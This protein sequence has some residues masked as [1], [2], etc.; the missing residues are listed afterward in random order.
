[1]HVAPAYEHHPPKEKKRIFFFCSLR[2]LRFYFSHQFLMFYYVMLVISVILSIYV[3]NRDS[4]S[5]S[6]LLWVFIIMALPVFGSLLYLLFGGRKIPKAL[7]VQ[8]RQAY[9]DYVA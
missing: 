5:S 6:K 7:M 8:D 9:A 4:D 3:I 2:G 1:M